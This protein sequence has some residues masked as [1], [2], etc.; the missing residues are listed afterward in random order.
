MPVGH[1]SLLSPGV[2]VI[3]KV[4]DSTHKDNNAVNRDQWP[5]L[6]NSRIRRRASYFFASNY[7]GECMRINLC[8][9]KS[10]TAANS[11]RKSVPS[12][13]STLSPMLLESSFVSMATIG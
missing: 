11:S 2:S 4:V 3:R 5:G 9:L 13:P 7:F 12:I 8:C 6:G 10:I 1:F